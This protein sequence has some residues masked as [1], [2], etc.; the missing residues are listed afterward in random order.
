MDSSK[1]DSSFFN[2][3]F[4]ACIVKKSFFTLVQNHI[5]ISY[6]PEGGYRLIWTE[7]T[8]Y[9]KRHEKCPSFGILRQRLADK[10]E[11]SSLEVLADIKDILKVDYDAVLKQFEDFVRKS[12]FLTSYKEIADIYNKGNKTQAFN[13]FKQAADDL[14]NFSLK[15]EQG[16]LIFSDFQKR[17]VERI[18]EASQVNQ[19]DNVF[20]TGVDLL[21][22]FM[23]GGTYRGETTLGL[24]D[25]GIGKSQ[26]LIFSGIAAA[27]RGARVVHIQGEGTR[28][29]IVDRYDTAWTGTLYKD[30]K[31]GQLPDGKVKALIKIIKKVG[32]GDIHVFCKDRFGAFTIPDIR[33]I[34][35]EVTRKYGPVDYIIADYLELFDPGDGIIYRPSEERFRQQAIGR[36]LKDLA[37]EQDAALFTMT[38]A[39]AVP[40]EAKENP[41]FVMTRW[42]LSEDKGKIRPFDNFFT[43]N[44]TRDEKTEQLMRIYCDKLRENSSGQIIKLAQALHRS[45]FYDRMRT[46]NDIY[47]NEELML[48]SK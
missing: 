48:I 40:P 2:E 36:G 7:L 6:I 18:I 45:R 23:D 25:S 26:A 24:G 15:A 1:L 47:T 19:R 9:V 22:H 16:D 28:K 35:Q 37:V 4:K 13:K 39:S 30:M 20:P 32:K 21:D 33:H 11:E 27:R 42:N 14:H 43:L 5:K 46:I 31:K 3:L 8:Q 29:Q 10:G 17:H 41:D 38:Q 44:Q 34:I 12:K